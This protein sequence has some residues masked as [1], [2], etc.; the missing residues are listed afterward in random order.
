MSFHRPWPVVTGH[1]RLR[2]HHGVIAGPVTIALFGPGVPTL[3]TATTVAARAIAAAG[4]F[5][6][7][8]IPVTIAVPPVATPAV[9]PIDLWTGCGRA[10]PR[11]HLRLHGPA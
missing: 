5:R 8:P 1:V 11:P 7:A 4:R 9:S 3:P 2:H 6:L 10:D